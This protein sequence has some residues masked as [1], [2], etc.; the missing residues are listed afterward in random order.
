MISSRINIAML[1]AAALLAAVPAQAQSTWNLTS[2]CA[3]AA[4]GYTNNFG[5]AYNCSA[6]STSG[7]N[8]MASVNISSW[9]TETGA[10]TW[11]YSGRRTITGNWVANTTTQYATIITYNGSTYSW[12]TYKPDG[13]DYT[14]TS[15]YSGSGAGA[16][17]KPNTAVSRTQSDPAGAGQWFANA[18]VG[19]YGGNGFGTTSRVEF[20][21]SPNHAVDSKAPGTTDMILLTFDRAVVLEQLGIGWSDGDA[22]MTL[23]RWTGTTAPTPLTSA[24]QPA[25]GASSALDGTLKTASNTGGWE[26]VKSFDLSSADVDSVVP[27]TKAFN[28][29]AT[30]ASSWWLVSTY[31]T[32]IFGSSSCITANGTTSTYC[33]AGDD[34]FKLNFLKTSN[35]ACVG[36]LG[37]GGVCTP[38]PPSP[39]GAVPEPGSMALAAM[40]GIAL[41][42]RRRHR[43]NFVSA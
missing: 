12:K 17:T 5:N 8:P 30:G 19:D 26:V 4:N 20:A 33:D 27:Q 40:A 28:T 35:Y 39:G 41:W 13:T 43:G 36:E 3:Q 34:A 9:S 6:A 15:T 29:T 23:L 18:Q 31:N 10:N 7:A 32:S 16:A 42:S 22:D 2:G 14:P 11:V 24:T 25:L 38:P 21:Q 37:S 1:A